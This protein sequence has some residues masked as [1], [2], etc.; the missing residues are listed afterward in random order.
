MKRKAIIYPWAWGVGYKL[1]MHIMQ[2]GEY[3]Y[4]G[5]CKFFRNLSDAQRFAS[6]YAD[7]TEY[8]GEVY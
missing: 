4:M 6:K 2:S 1:S 5:F 3:R 7:V 8:A